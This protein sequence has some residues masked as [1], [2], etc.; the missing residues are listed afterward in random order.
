[1]STVDAAGAYARE[2]W[3]NWYP[4]FIEAVE[5][6]APF[7]IRPFIRTTVDQLWRPRP[8][9]SLI[10]DAAHVTPPFGGRDTNMATLDALLLSQS[11][12]R[13]DDDMG[14]AITGY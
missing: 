10:G 9:V 3:P 13:A 11:L 14:E 7:S 12:L 6:A 4:A 1:M 8:D 5:A 2:I